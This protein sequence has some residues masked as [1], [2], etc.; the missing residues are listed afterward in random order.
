MTRISDVVKEKH[1]VSEVHIER[2]QW[3]CA[4]EMRTVLSL[5]QL[6]R[7]K[8][9]LQRNIQV[10]IEFK[11]LLTLKLRFFNIEIKILLTLIS[12]F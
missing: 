9:D 8:L 10:Y 7:L 2:K 5:S 11:I 6:R 1:F 4:L 3:D 12:A